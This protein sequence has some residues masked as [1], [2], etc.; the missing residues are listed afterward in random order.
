MRYLVADETTQLRNAHDFF[1]GVLYV[2]E[3]TP[4]DAKVLLFRDARFFYYGERYGIVWYSPEIYGKEYFWYWGQPEELLQFFVSL[5]ITHVLVDSYSER[6]L[7]FDRSGIGFVLAEPE[8]A[9]LVFE[10]GTARVYRLRPDD[11]T[12]STI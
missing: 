3:Q 5:G 8:L 11:S 1:E 9:E 10:H 4:P 2:N 12:R 7:G 6:L